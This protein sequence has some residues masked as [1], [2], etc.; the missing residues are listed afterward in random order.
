[1]YFS[2]IELKNWK[3]FKNADAR[4]GRRIFLIGPSASGKSN[5]LD[6]L[7]FLHDVATV[8]LGMAVASRD[9]VSRLRCLSARQ[10][11][12]IRIQ[13]TLA[14][15]DGTDAWSYALEFTQDSRGTPTV[16][17]ERVESLVDGGLVVL[18]RPDAQD[19]ADP[20]RRSQ[21][22]LEQI[23]AN[24][25]FRP[26]AE[27][28]SSVAY[29][30]LV[31]QVVRDPKGFSGGP[32]RNDP[33]GR[34]LLLRLWTTQAS[35]R[36]AWLRRIAS[37]LRQAVPQLE[38]LAAEMDGTGTPHLVGRYTHWRPSAARH[39]ESQL[40]DGTLRLFGL[41]WSLFEGSGP[42]LL[43]EP[44]LSLHPEVVRSIPQ[45]LEAVRREIR[46][47]KRPQVAQRQ[48]IMST[49]AEE[50]LR[51]KGIGPDEVIRIE[52]TP[53]GSL[54]R[55]ADTDDRALMREGLTAADV[56]LPKAAPAGGQ[57]HFDFSR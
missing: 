36:D 47:M 25:D 8:G 57:L 7:R 43:E 3:N 24:R 44:E 21:T 18:D 40:S 33:Y 22:A 23:V 39:T 11:S 56:L 4:L 6:A 2:R 34:D 29:H 27:L 52:P 55:L 45:M 20:L 31:P 46:L 14:D 12:A 28:F 37:V 17:A 35:T 16:S 48:I 51:D 38:S 50:I 32:V 1:M 5:L 15:D 41:M 19:A 10:S 54:L 42:L 26:I 49:H 30:H 9:G 13:V 53:E